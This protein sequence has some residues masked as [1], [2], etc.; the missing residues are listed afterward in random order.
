[1]HRRPPERPF[2]TKKEGATSEN[3]GYISGVHGGRE[4]IF[5]FVNQTLIM[6]VQL[7]P[8]HQFLGF[9]VAEMSCIWLRGVEPARGADRSG[10]KSA[11]LRSAEAPCRAAQAGGV[12][13]EA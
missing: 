13:A 5:C 11:T 8:P 10:R 4:N 1:M 12:I 2:R 6:M 9:P 7:P 3:V